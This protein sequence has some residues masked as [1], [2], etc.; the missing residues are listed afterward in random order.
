[1]FVAEGAHAVIVD[2]RRKAFYQDK[3]IQLIKEAKGLQI[4]EG[5]LVDLIKR[6]F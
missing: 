5:E 1:M 2:R 4:S 3:V 6:G